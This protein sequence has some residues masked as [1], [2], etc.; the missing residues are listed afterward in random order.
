MLELEII[1]KSDIPLGYRK[2]HYVIDSLEY[3]K[4]IKII[5][6]DKETAGKQR[7]NVLANFRKTRISSHNYVICT[8]VYPLDSGQFVLFVWKEIKS[9]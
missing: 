5:Y 3:N 2:W 4:A 8:R 9:E 6:P 7:C 1:N